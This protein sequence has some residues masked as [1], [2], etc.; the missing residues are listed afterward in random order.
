[1][2]PASGLGPHRSLLPLLFQKLFQL[3]LDPDHPG[4]LLFGLQVFVV[5]L[6]PGV[7][8]LDWVGVVKLVEAQGS[9]MGKPRRVVL[10]GVN[11]LSS[12]AGSVRA[13]V[14]ARW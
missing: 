13:A 1:M 11:L 3:L 8:D 5:C 4:V 14:V 6:E 2:S 9:L 12:D 7:V 10:I